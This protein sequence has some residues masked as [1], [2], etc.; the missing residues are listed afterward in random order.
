MSPWQEPL[1][2]FFLYTK[3]AY[4]A[5]SSPRDSAAS[6][7]PVKKDAAAASWK[8]CSFHFLTHIC[9]L[10]CHRS[11][12]NKHTQLYPPL[13]LTS[14]RSREGMNMALKPGCWN[15][16]KEP[17]EYSHSSI[18]RTVFLKWTGWLVP[19]SRIFNVGDPLNSC[20]Q[21]CWEDYAQRSWKQSQILT[22]VVST[23]P[24]LLPAARLRS[25]RCEGV[26][27]GKWEEPRGGRKDNPK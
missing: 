2:S 7:L 6:S 5:R 13:H 25:S 24:I 18:F 10:S 3:E 23:D 26:E 17:S 19:Y 11:W 27:N 21:G 12:F 16:F 9:Y 22:S 8:V 4:P 14:S 15:A 1:S 20:L